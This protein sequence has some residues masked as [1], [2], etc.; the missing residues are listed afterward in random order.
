MG[1]AST[2]NPTLSLA[3]LFYI[4]ISCSF[5]HTRTQTPT[6]TTAF[7]GSLSISPGA[8]ADL[9]APYW[10]THLFD[11][12]TNLDPVSR[13]ATTLWMWPSVSFH[14]ISSVPACMVYEAY[15]FPLG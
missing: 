14:C 15:W 13:P 9:D 3:N 5:Y 7:N 12:Y 6:C 1:E 2:S 8:E 10:S 4:H 11:A